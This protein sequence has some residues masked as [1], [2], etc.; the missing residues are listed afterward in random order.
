MP[1]A[2]HGRHGPNTMSTWL[3]RPECSTLMQATHVVMPSPCTNLCAA[4]RAREALT[5][6]ACGG[7]LKIQSSHA[8]SPPCVSPEHAG[9]R[10]QTQSAHL[11][12]LGLAHHLVPR[13]TQRLAQLLACG[14]KQRL[15]RTEEYVD[16]LAAP[17]RVMEVSHACTVRCIACLLDAHHAY[18]QAL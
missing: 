2:E 14:A 7:C 9:S 6:C 8:G 15:L 17:A 3:I 12:L 4:A 10:R 1:V 11:G 5:C 18:K 13:A 16:Q